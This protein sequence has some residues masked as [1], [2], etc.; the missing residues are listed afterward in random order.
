VARAIGINHVALE[1]GDVDDALAWYGRFLDFELRGK[2]ARMAF[3]DLG[4]QFIALSA[5]RGQPADEGRHFGL[6]VD[7]KEAVRAALLDGGV[8]VP[9]S[10]HLRFRDPWGNNVEIVGY[11]DIQFT[12]APEVLRALAAEG[13]EKTDAAREELRAKGLL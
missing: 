4:D 12:K 1:V 7:D 11:R 8:S 3:I 13:I 9:P 6:V 2:S 5:G 10:G